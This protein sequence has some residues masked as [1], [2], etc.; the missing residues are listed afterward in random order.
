MHQ[1]S[2]L[3]KPHCSVAS[4]KMFQ[5]LPFI[6]IFTFVGKI[7]QLTVN[8]T[9]YR[10]FKSDWTALKHYNL[11]NESPFLSF[12]VNCG[13]FLCVFLILLVC[14][15]CS[16][17]WGIQNVPHREQL[18]CAVC[19]HLRNICIGRLYFHVFVSCAVSDLVQCWFWKHISQSSVVL[20]C[21]V[22]NWTS[23]SY[24][25]FAL[26]TTNHLWTCQT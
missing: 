9:E 6:A 11:V 2:P 18:V 4:W 20:S 24:L 8:C 1:H 5:V 17:N 14:C 22:E 25:Y 3:S 19:C 23:K 7:L 12:L 16:R 21:L 26:G 10:L 15:T 13:Y